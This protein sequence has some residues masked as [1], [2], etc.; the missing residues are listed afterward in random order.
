VA[1]SAAPVNAL[2][3]PDL[4]LWRVQWAALPGHQEVLHCHVPHYCAMFEKLFR[5]PRPWRYGHLYLPEG[6]K[7]L[8]NP[9]Y[10]LQPGSQV[11][12]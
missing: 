3:L 8:G 9:T 5:Q 2:L 11:R 7:N 12:W 4:P 6:S 1:D 10:A